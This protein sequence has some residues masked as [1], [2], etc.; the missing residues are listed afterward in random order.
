MAVV[1]QEVLL[2]YSADLN[3]FS[4]FL[5]AETYTETFFSFFSISLSLS[6]LIS[7]SLPLS[8]ANI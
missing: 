4:Y 3:I 1:V 5:P 8:I 2:S 7:L 6:L